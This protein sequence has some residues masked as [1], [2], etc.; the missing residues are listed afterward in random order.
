MSINTDLHKVGRYALVRKLG[1]ARVNMG[2]EL[3][4]SSSATLEKTLAFG[5]LALGFIAGLKMNAGIATLGGIAV[6]GASIPVLQDSLMKDDKKAEQ[7]LGVVM[8]T[9]GASSAIVGFFRL[10][11]GSRK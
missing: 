1:L 11:F 10:I 7:A 6:W 3:G 2:S 4:Q 5:G 9:A 8:L